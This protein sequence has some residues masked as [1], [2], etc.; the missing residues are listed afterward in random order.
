MGPREDTHTHTHVAINR[1]WQD[2]VAVYPGFT[3][4][5]SRIAWVSQGPKVS[6]SETKRWIQTTKK[7]LGNICY[8][9]PWDWNVWY[10]CMIDVWCMVIFAYFVLMIMVHVGNLFAVHPMRSSYG[11]VRVSNTRPKWSYWIV[12]ASF[13]RSMILSLPNDRDGWRCFFKGSFYFLQ[14]CWWLELGMA[15]SR[16]PNSKVVG[17]LH[18]SG[19]K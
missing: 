12:Q 5:R 14:F 15:S 19:T 10:V 17:D 13:F 6:F 9:K 2:T 3:G 4:V 1:A 8:C 11:Q 18:L 16:D 7:V